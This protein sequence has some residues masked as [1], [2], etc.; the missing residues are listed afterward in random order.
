MALLLMFTIAFM[1]LSV[2]SSN[3]DFRGR[4]MSEAMAYARQGLE[5]VRSIAEQDFQQL[6]VGN[7]GIGTASNVYVLSG[8]TNIWNGYTRSLSVGLVQRN[9]AGDIV[10]TG[11]TT[12][13]DT[14]SVTSAIQWNEGSNPR[15]TTLTTY[16]TDW[17]KILQAG[18]TIQKIVINHGG[19]KVPA[20]FAP[21]LVGTGTVTLGEAISLD[22]G[23]YTVFETADPNYVQ[24]FGGDCDASGNVTL[25]AG[26]SKTCTITNEEKRATVT[27][28]KT[29]VNYG[30]TKVASDFAP[31]KVGT[32][33]VTLGSGTTIDVG[34]Y[35]VSET[36]DA[37]YMQTFSGDCDAAG[38]IILEYDDVKTC[39][40]TN[41]QKTLPTVTSPVATNIAATTVTLGANVTSLGV[42]AVITARGTCYG[43]TPAPTTNCA[44]EG[45]TT[46]GVFTQNRTGLTPGTLYYFRGFATN[47]TGIAY[48]ADATFTTSLV[49]AI[50]T[51]TT[52]TVTS[53]TTTTATL[54]AN[55]TSLG[56]PA[57]I[58]A[59]GTCWG[60][61]PAPTTNCVAQ[62]GTTTGIFTQARTGFTP[63]TLYYFRGYATNTTGTAYS[64][65]GTFT[66]L[67]AACTTASALVGTPTLYNSA[68]SVTAVATKP[69]GVAQ[70]DIMFAH[71][72][73]F[74]GTDRLSTIPTGW[75]QIGKHKNGAYNQALYYKVAGASEGA[76]YTFGLSASSKVAVTLSAYRGCFNPADPIAVSSN[77]EYVTN[78]T[79][80]RAASMTLPSANMTVLMFPSIYNTRVRTFANPLTQGG[81]WTEDYDHGATT[82]DFTRAG[83]RKYI[84]AA[85]VIG[86]IDSIGRTGTTV[87]HAFGVGLKP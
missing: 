34:T 58:S 5:A 2:G 27:V 86:V 36:V 3:G 62:G 19:S 51:V 20:D 71:I 41:E 23:T 52:P 25:D 45:G 42:P 1:Q 18:L 12:D 35:T 29:V 30:G 44:P 80:Y 31:Y 85:G 83:Y 9:G 73:H 4:K 46:T 63:G 14:R 81:D 70:N 15:S 13:Y 47:A 7:H 6:T 8:S 66:T 38:Q 53:I 28:N 69:T 57:S 39:T 79:T 43:T 16:L 33:T 48:S 61:T 55:V 22:A 87:K 65:D 21:Y 59:R 77:T 84:P 26:D 74:N 40:I 24:T 17:R 75:I 49:N 72:L 10:Q 56:V 64:A 11:G 76:S 82:S 32:T 78:N 60:T 54:G 37:N 50:P 67:A 68:G